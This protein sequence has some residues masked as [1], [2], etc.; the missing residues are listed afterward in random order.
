M[1][2]PDRPSSQPSARERIAVRRRAHSRMQRAR[3]QR[4]ALIAGG[5]LLALVVVIGGALALSRAERTL[6]T[7]QEEDPRLRVTAA[8]A[9]PVAAT[10]VAPVVTTDPAAPVLPSAIPAA[11]VAVAPPE[12]FAAP[13][14]I[15]L[16][17]VDK[18][19]NPDDGV[20]SDTLI[21]VR[22]DPQ[23]RTASMLSIPRDTAALIPNIG[24]A[25]INSAYGFGYTNA[26]ALYGPGTSPDAAGGA[27][28][29]Q[30]LEQLLGVRVDYIA[31]VDF[32]GFERLIDTVGGIVID[33]QTPIYDAA[34]PT[35]NYGMQRIYIAPG[36]Q[37]M[38]GRTALIY[39]RTR[40]T[41]SDF[42][43]S[44]RQ[45]EVLRALLQQVRERGILENITLLPRWAEVLEENVRTTLPISDLAL[46][47]S[48]AALARELTPD[49][50][51]QVS[52]NPND[53]ALDREDGTDLYWNTA[54]LAAL[55]ARW[56]TG[57]QPVV[58]TE[59]PTAA[60]AEVQPTLPIRLT[61]P[62]DVATAVPLTPSPVDT[63][64]ARVQVLNAAAVEGI[65]GQVSRFLAQRGFLLADPETLTSRYEQTMIID[66]SGMPQTRARLAEVLGIEPP[67]VLATPGPD[68]PPQSLGV[69]ILVVVGSNFRPEWL[70]D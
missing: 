26:E 8:I 21:L 59:A 2:D 52:I 32:T 41:S 22:I 49:R 16:L 43:R 6:N 1:S 58:A 65:A 4:M 45:Q 66:Y 24:W 63:E 28:A 5:L 70:T 35:E 57:P 69:D 13:F 11:T 17:G 56:E 55:V 18:R 64:R 53:V 20:R 62:A 36:L 37:V 25:K 51:L 27:L 34:Y 46:L 30:S 60:A 10:P 3:M 39:A 33:P 19:P 12:G 14:N 29:A 9:T 47:N 23:A 54:D 7:I 50:I 48:L 40:H 44:R 42:D 67:Y 68:A 61:P 31:Q 38:D 15:L